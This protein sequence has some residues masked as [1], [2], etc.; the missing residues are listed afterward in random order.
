VRIKIIVQ[1]VIALLIVVGIFIYFVSGISS[2][3]PAIKQYEFNGDMKQFENKLDMLTSQ[4]KKVSF[5]ITDT[6]G[7]KD[8]GYAYYY[9]LNFDNN[10]Y[11]LK[12]EEKEFPNSI[13]AEISIVGA[14]N[15]NKR[16][17]GYRI[18]DD[19]VKDLVNVFD[20]EIIKGLNVG[21]TEFLID[22]YG[23]LAFF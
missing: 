19:G 2:V 22:N 12:C 5:S 21:Q 18:G 1:I 15:F 8:N 10:E 20:E 17:G 9:M 14:H 13:K 23:H 3:Y 7:N 11:D 16:L 4:N 6:T